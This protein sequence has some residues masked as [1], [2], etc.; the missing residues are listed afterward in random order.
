MLRITPDILSG[1]VLDPSP[2]GGEQCVF[3]ADRGS[4]SSSTAPPPPRSRAA[5]LGTMKKQSG[6]DRSSVMGVPE[7][8]FNSPHVVQIIPSDCS[9][10]QA[11]ARAA[12]LLIDLGLGESDNAEE[13]AAPHCLPP[14]LPAPLSLHCA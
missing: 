5:D 6:C 8:C 10:S 13:I 12:G 3:F 11:L 9:K 4:A 7:G 14:C 1:G 2:S